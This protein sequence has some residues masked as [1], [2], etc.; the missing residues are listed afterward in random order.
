MSLL[1]Y[2]VWPDRALVGVDTL[3]SDFD[4]TPH[5]AEASKVLLLPHTN[6]LLAF[7]GGQH[8]LAQIFLFCF[9]NKQSDFDG[10]DQQLQPALSAGHEGFIQTEIARGVPEDLA[11]GGAEFVVIG[12]SRSAGEM[13]AKLYI[14]QPNE[15]EF[16]KRDQ[17]CI[18]APNAGW[19]PTVAPRSRS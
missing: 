13:R 14:R 19:S 9:M 15:R 3:C 2:R 11:R 18:L 17:S 6:V 16:S 7:R 10:L 5:Q 8:L 4:G 12:Y 1:N